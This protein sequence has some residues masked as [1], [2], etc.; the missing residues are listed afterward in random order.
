[1]AALAGAQG[2]NASNSADNVA[3]IGRASL[4]AALGGADQMTYNVVAAV[5]A[6]AQK[7]GAIP[8]TTTHFDHYFKNIRHQ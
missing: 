7:D 1:M 5:A 4:I 2:L 3:A 6:A 8:S